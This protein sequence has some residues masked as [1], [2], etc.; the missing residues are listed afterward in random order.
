MS[1]EFPTSAADVPHDAP[2]ATVLQ[3]FAAH[4]LRVVDAMLGIGEP[5][6]VETLARHAVAALVLQH[7]VAER[8]LYSRWTTVRDA[9]TYGASIGD[10]AAA[11]GLDVD[12]VVAGLRSWAAG[13]L[14]HGLVT[15]AEHDAVVALVEDVQR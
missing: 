4:T 7:T 8:V 1:A 5:L 3:A 9:L 10:V 6:P 13:Q 11:M 15:E 2:L 14:R 12:E